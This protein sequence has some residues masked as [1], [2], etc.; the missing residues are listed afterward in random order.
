[1]EKDSQAQ[2]GHDLNCSVVSISLNCLNQDPN[3]NHDDEIIDKKFTENLNESV[4]CDQQKGQAELKV[5]AFVNSCF[6]S[7]QLDP[8]KDQISRLRCAQ[9]FYEL[10]IGHKYDD[11]W[12]DKEFNQLFDLFQEDDQKEL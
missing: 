11:A 10:M 7:M 4:E 8:E 2:V 9:L 12:D 5:E 6:Y 3:H 1:M